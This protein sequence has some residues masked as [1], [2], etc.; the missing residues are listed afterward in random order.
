M[1]IIK[2]LVTN[3]DFMKLIINSDKVVSELV[4]RPSNKTL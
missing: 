2:D 1:E 3:E 4:K